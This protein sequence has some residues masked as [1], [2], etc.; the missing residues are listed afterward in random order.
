MKINKKKNFILRILLI[1]FLWVG[2]GLTG[3]QI[4]YAWDNTSALVKTAQLRG[5]TWTDLGVSGVSTYRLKDRCPVC[6]V[7]W[8]YFAAWNTRP[9]CTTS[10]TFTVSCYN[11]NVN[12]YANSSI[13]QYYAT[14]NLGFTG[15]LGH[16]YTS[17]I[18]SSTV[19]NGG[20]GDGY[21]YRKCSHC[22]DFGKTSTPITYYIKYLDTHIT[23][24]STSGSM[25]NSSVTYDTNI[26]LTNAYVK[27]GNI[28]KGWAT[29]SQG[30][31]VYTDGQQV[32]NLT[33]IDGSTITLYAVWEPI[34]FSVSYDAGDGVIEGTTESNIERIA[35]YEEDV[36]LSVKAEKEGVVFIGWA[37]SDN[38]TVG[39]ASIMMP[40]Q[41]IQLHAVYSLPVS[42]MKEVIYVAWDKNNAENFRIYPL[43]LNYI[44]PSGYSYSRLNIQAVNDLGLESEESL[45]WGIVLY[46]NAGNCT[47]LHDAT[48]IPNRYLQT[49]IHKVWDIERQEYVYYTTTDELVYEGQIY[50][51]RH[52]IEGDEDYPLGF[53]PSSIEESYV[54]TKDV[55]SYA[56]YMPK[57][58]KLYFDANG[59]MCNTEYKIVYMNC[60]YGELP[61][62][63]R[64][65]YDF[66][67][68]YTD[69]GISIRNTDICTIASDMTVYA[70][71]KIHSNHVVYDFWTNGGTDV[72]EYTK[73]FEYGT[74]IDFNVQ[75]IKPGWEFIG[76]NIYPDATEALES[77]AMPD[78]DLLL[79]AIFK[80]DIVAT[81]IDSDGINTLTREYVSSIYS[82]REIASVIVPEQTQI[83]DWISLGWSSEKDY[84]AEVVVL[85]QTTI[86]IKNDI[87]YYGRYQRTV[88]I[89]YDTNGSSLEIPI[90][91]KE[92]YFNAAGTEMYPYV[93]IAEG[94]PMEKNSFVGWMVREEEKEVEIIYNPKDVVML[95]KDICL[96]AKWDKYPEI[97]AYSRYFTLTEAQN[98]SI[99]K[100]KLLENVIATDKE[101][102]VLVNGRDVIVYDYNPNILKNMTETGFV[103][104]A[105]QATD[106]F[107]NIGRKT[108]QIHVVDTTV[109]QSLRMKYARFISDS[110]FTDEKGEFL[111]YKEGGLEETSIWKVESY[112][113]SLLQNT[114]TTTTFEEE[115]IFKQEDIQQMKDYTNIYGHFLNAPEIFKQLFESCKQK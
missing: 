21:W 115:W 19:G 51:P 3:K 55:T 96:V 37:Y 88:S 12:D 29:T 71:W 66:I 94:P 23:G 100:T 70:R 75:A 47:T 20:T 102:G 78:E 6:G 7:D 109:K 5:W 112:K 40:A 97:E 89:I 93:E 86:N 48:P 50:T 91:E 114:L 98:G 54:V 68:W 69:D 43:N 105:Y 59:G 13:H 99:T 53:Y 4:V 90:V 38:A 49:V 64:K 79:Y 34:E 95:K 65:G 84:D 103:E 42:D 87:T 111:S 101:D 56:Y 72:T 85:S 8:L 36:D 31:V 81:F 80:K 44:D 110:F 32:K 11:S 74:P 63:I 67:G 104:I 76:W 10:G 26:E 9:T 58:Y 39:L 25:N 82:D 113:N 1:A 30:D 52:L 108:V 106:S 41:D 83:P 17:S 107:G 24:S 28:F 46:D 27:E 22:S 57:E 16:E 62:A 14:Q 92:A 33:V 15:A 45:E 61:V 2:I 35:Y 77:Y 73:E 18:M 60:H